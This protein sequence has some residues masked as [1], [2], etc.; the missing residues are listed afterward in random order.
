MSDPRRFL[1]WIR[2]ASLA[3]AALGALWIYWRFELLELPG[4]GC[5]PLLRLAPGSRLVVDRRPPRLA[6]GDV[7]LFDLGDGSLGI[8]EVER[9]AA[10]GLWLRTD[11][12]GCP[13]PDSDELGWVAP[14]RVGGRM[15]FAFAGDEPAAGR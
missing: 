14:E 13:G 9:V 6:A 5:S 1:P 10:E 12:P 8:A 2:R 7:V 15:V 11:A 3:A 4:A